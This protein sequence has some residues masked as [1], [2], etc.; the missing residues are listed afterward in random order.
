MTSKDA[1]QELQV[2]LFCAFALFYFLAD[3]W[4]WSDPRSE[5]ERR[6]GFLAAKPSQLEQE[7]PCICLLFFFIQY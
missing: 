3:E 1:L 7:G 5:R 4:R 2:M 6:E